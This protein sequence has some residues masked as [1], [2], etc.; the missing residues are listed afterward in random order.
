VALTQSA[1]DAAVLPLTSKILAD[2][3]GFSLVVDTGPYYDGGIR[4]LATSDRKLEENPGDV[5]QMVRATLRA[6]AWVRENR[7]DAIQ[8][9]QE[10]LNEDPATTVIYYDHVVADYSATGEVKAEWVQKQ[11]Q[12]MELWGRPARITDEARLVDRRPWRAATAR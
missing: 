9:L 1:I 8:V 6:M 7:A 10:M 11:L 4:G 3:D 2:R 5:E 12:E